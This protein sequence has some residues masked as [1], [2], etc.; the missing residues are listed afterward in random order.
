MHLG[1]NSD[2][3]DEAVLNA[4]DAWVVCDGDA[5][6]ISNVARRC[7]DGKS[8][9]TGMSSGASTC[10]QMHNMTATLP[11]QNEDNASQ[12]HSGLGFWP[13]PQ[14]RGGH[15][16]KR[17]EFLPLVLFQFLGGPFL[18]TYSLSLH[19]IQSILTRVA[20]MHGAMGHLQIKNGQSSGKKNK[21][22]WMLQLWFAGS[23]TQPKDPMCTQ[24]MDVNFLHGFFLSLVQTKPGGTP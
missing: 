17:N 19:F 3:S 23:V 22:S 4:G 16:E 1:E 20:N 9:A 14:V 24:D 21:F 15:H 7:L 18:H 12:F 5:A 13:W 11:N 10:E 2:S 6:D 8:G